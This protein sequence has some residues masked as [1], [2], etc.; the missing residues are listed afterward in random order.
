MNPSTVPMMKVN[1][2]PTKLQFSPDYIQFNPWFNYFSLLYDYAPSNC[3]VY[4]LYL[5]THQSFNS[6]M[7]VHLL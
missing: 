1:D 2:L 6:Y 5:I 3:V 7:L 4:Y